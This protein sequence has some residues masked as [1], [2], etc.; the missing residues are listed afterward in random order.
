[1]LSKQARAIRRAI[2]GHSKRRV[3]NPIY[4]GQVPA[5]CHNEVNQT[6]KASEHEGRHNSTGIDGPGKG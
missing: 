3:N 5:L 1:M 4:T 2:S 6:D